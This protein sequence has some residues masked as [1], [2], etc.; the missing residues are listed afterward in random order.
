MFE[1]NMKK[2]YDDDG[3]TM[4]GADCTKRHLRGL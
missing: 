1:K 4:F 2:K 3:K